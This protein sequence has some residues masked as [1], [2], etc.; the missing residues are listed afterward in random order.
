M[1]KKTLEIPNVK[2]VLIRPKN[3]LKNVLMVLK[4][5]LKNVVKPLLKKLR[6]LQSES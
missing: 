2:N 4:N 6:K 5:Y 1:T 3:K